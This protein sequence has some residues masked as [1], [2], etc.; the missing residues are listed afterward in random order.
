MKVAALVL[1]LIMLCLSQVTSS[2][3]TG[4]IDR[5][6]AKNITVF[7][8][9]QDTFGAAPVNMDTGDAPGDLYFDIRSVDLPM[10]CAH[11]DAHSAHD[12]SNAEAT[13]SPSC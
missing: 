13:Y 11:P 3:S 1:W 12:C 5:K 10:E 8:I 9:N 2:A 4:S 6:F 7:H